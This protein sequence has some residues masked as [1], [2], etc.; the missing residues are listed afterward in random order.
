MNAFHFDASALVKR[1]TP[2]TGA[3]LIDRLLDHLTLKRSCLALTAAEIVWA[4]VRK[5]NAGRLSRQ[6]Y[7][8]AVVNLNA[9]VTQSSRVNTLSVEIV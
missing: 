6:S 1:Y 9:E 5:R 2:E 8:Q 4:L 7:E 3:E